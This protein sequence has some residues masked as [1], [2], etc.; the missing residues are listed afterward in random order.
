[1]STTLVLIKYLFWPETPWFS[2]IY[3][4]ISNSTC[5][6]KCYYSSPVSMKGKEITQRGY[7]INYFFL[8]Q[9]L[10]RQKA[11]TSIVPLNTEGLQGWS[12]TTLQLR[13]SSTFP[14]SFPQNP[15][16]KLKVMDRQHSP[17]G[18]FWFC[19]D[20]WLCTRF[21]W[22]AEVGNDIFPIQS[23][24]FGKLKSLHL[25]VF[26]PKHAEGEML[27]LSSRLEFLLPAP[28]AGSVIS[29][30]LSHELSAGFLFCLFY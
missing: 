16:E 13:E 4:S 14:P 19:S 15:P 26:P 6:E 9:L 21:G 30:S 18:P 10:S 8:A 1:M 7:T 29:V 2:I 20:L 23:G 28:A 25:K 24:A 27:G 22:I 12:R 17:H 11:A 3:F 5:K